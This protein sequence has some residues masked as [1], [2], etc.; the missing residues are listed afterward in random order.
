MATEPSLQVGVIADDLTGAGDAGLQFFNKGLATWVATGPGGL[1]PPEAEAISVNAGGRARSPADA[2]DG[3]AQAGAWLRAQGCATFYHKVDS[4]LRGNLA[5]EVGRLLHALELDL[6][7]VSP[8]FPDAGR[9]TIGGFQLVDGVP[10]ALSSYGQ[11]PLGP[12]EESHLPTFLQQAGNKTA[13]IDLRTVLMGWEKIV[14]SVAEARAKGTRAVVVDAARTED[15]ASIGRAIAHLGPGVLPVGSAGLAR[16]LPVSRS[17]RRIPRLLEAD[18]FDRPMGH[19]RVLGRTP[20][21]LIVSGSCNPVTLAQ[22]AA[23]QDEARI[24]T[25]DVRQLL[26]TEGGGTWAAD[27]HEELERTARQALQG[28]LAGRDVVVTTTLDLEQVAR[29]QALGRDLGLSAWQL[30]E[31][32]CVAL[33]SLARRLW[34]TAP[35]GGL[36][37]AG[38]QTAAAVCKALAADCL[39]IVGEAI[40]AVPILRPAGIDL[41]MVTKSGGFGPPDA[42]IRIAGR[43]R[44]QAG[45]IAT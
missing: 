30:G 28:L 17:A 24:V 16:E 23:V 9:I 34:S 4:T 7:V 10:V 11:D 6:A 20:P 41:R 44:H 42:L 1:I 12:V 29:D 5:A 27:L 39:E 2:A 33:G 25:V 45:R 21:V 26:L 18:P 36:V 3:V 15:L 37:V 8:A 43:L 40:P 31:Q 35:I 19:V 22:L 13:L 14:G 38:G 32:L